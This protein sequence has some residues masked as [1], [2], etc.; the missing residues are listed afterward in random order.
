MRRAVRALAGLLLGL[1]AAGV[2]GRAIS[3]AVD[4]TDPGEVVRVHPA[5]RAWDAGAR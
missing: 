2:L 1:A 4:H 3:C 5:I